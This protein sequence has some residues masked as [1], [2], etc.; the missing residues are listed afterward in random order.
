MKHD[1][2]TGVS[3]TVNKS[4][5]S[6]K[7]KTTIRTMPIDS[8]GVGS[9]LT[10]RLSFPTWKMCTTNLPR[11]RRGLDNNDGMDNGKGLEINANPTDCSSI[12]SI[13]AFGMIYGTSPLRN[14][15]NS[16]TYTLVDLL[17]QDELFQEFGDL[18]PSCTSTWEARTRSRGW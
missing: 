9:G 12:Y 8:V 10:P 16:G 17:A 6:E 13:E 14:L 1:P 7:A 5:P 11:T 15:L 2:P 3:V 18:S 4:K